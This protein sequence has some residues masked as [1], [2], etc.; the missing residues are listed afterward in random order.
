MGRVLDKIRARRKAGTGFWAFL[1]A[2]GGV[3]G[4]AVGVARAVAV[5][6]RARHGPDDERARNADAA[7]DAIEDDGE[8]HEG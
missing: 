6:R 2:I 4:L 8:E 3:R 1:N 7:A 5:G